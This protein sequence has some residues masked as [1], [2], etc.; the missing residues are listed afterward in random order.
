MLNEICNTLKGTNGIRN[1]TYAAL[2]NLIS[3][4]YGDAVAEV[5]DTK[6]FVVGDLTYAQSGCDVTGLLLSLSVGYTLVE[7]I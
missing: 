5:I 3:F 2:I 1:N 4:M 6:F 7:K